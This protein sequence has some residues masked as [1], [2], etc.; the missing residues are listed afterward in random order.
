[1]IGTTEDS[2]NDSNWQVAPN[3]LDHLS[4]DKLCRMIY[5]LD[6]KRNTLQDSL[7]QQQ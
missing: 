7:Y 2:N 4:R 6:Y 3:F 5:R 1:M